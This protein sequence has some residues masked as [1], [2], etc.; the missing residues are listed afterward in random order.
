MLGMP[1]APRQ[2]V[3]KH[4]STSAKGAIALQSTESP[5]LAVRSLAQ[6]TA[7]LNAWV[8][9]DLGALA[10]NVAAIRSVLKPTTELVGVVKANAYGHGAVAVASE[11]E[12]LGVDRFAVAWMA[13]ALELRSAGVRRPILVLEHVF[14]ADAEAAV[15]NGITCTIHSRELAEA[16]SIAATRHNVNAKVHVK[17]D[18]GLHRFGLP[19]DA[20]IELA[21]YA[22]LLPGVEVE[23]LWTHMA[24]A[25]DADDSFSAEQLQRFE[26]VRE[27][28]DWVPFT[29]AAN[30]ATTLRRPEL[31]FGGVRAGISLYG[32]CP[33]N[34]PDPGLKPLMSVKARLA[35]VQV[36]EAGE[37][38]SYGL[39]WRAPARS[40][41]GLVPVGYGDGW[42]R[43]LG[44]LGHVLVAGRRCPMIGRVCMDQFLVDLTHLPNAER[45]AEGEEVVLLGSQGDESI[46]A[47]E[48]ADEIGTISWEVVAALLPRI[49]RIFHREGQV[50]LPG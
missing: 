39:T 46:T 27:R 34:T 36:L 3:R 2:R 26:V 40:V 31:H 13:E 48:V 22:R 49:P 21:E 25:D 16:F 15:L 29:H 11:A 37:G 18:T 9:V 17:V 45:I 5:A 7:N 47:G 12:R 24:N 10:T 23:G 35:R 41:V 42:R 33:P 30:S 14:A 43:S 6:A 32:L 1:H 28:L 38:V 8:E 4:G 19:G 50:V 20:A 44:N